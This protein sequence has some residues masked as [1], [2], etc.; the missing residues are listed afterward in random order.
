MSRYIDV[1]R[2]ATTHACYKLT[3]TIMERRK[4]SKAWLHFTKRDAN[5]AVC[6]Q[7]GISISC[8]GSNT[9]NMLKHLSCQHG[10]KLQEC[11][12]F[13]SLRRSA[14][15]TGTS[16]TVTSVDDGNA[17]IICPALAH[18]RFATASSM[19]SFSLLKRT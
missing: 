5:Y 10:I 15:V 8:K 17:Q 6:N 4:R 18:Y 14:N 3:T 9:S 11:H 12:V 19:H 2:S 1:T 13:D 7:C 16:S